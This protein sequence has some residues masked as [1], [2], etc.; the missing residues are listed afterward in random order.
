MLT[1]GQM[2]SLTIEKPAAGGRMIARVNGQVVLVSGAIPGE[3]VT[4]RVERVS[5]SVAYA[6]TVTADEPS[7]DRRRATGDPMCGGSLYSHIAYPR[8]LEIKSRVI[9]D[10][11]ARIGHV[12]LPSPIRVA[13]SPEDGYRMRARL[14]VRGRRIGFFREATHDVCDVRQTRQLLPQS[15]DVIDRLTATI[16][17]LALDAIR[18]IE[19]AENV[20]ASDRV[21]ALDTIEAIDSRI[22]DRLASADGLTGFVSASGVHG[23]P[24][25]TDRVE[26]DGTPV[27]LRRHVLAFFQGNRHLLRPLVE[28]VVAQVPAGGELVD[29]YAGVGLFA[30][31]AA[32]V[33]RIR[34]TAVEGDRYAAADLDANA[35]ATQGAV[36]P[37]HDAV[38]NF[39]SSFSTHSREPERTLIVDPPRTGMSRE[40][41]EGALRLQATRIIYVSCDVATLAR[42]SRRIIDAG[43]AIS[44]ADAFDLFPNTPHV[45]TVL[46]FDR[47]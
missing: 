45:E 33:R 20:D 14:H 25:V 29:L 23:R 46:V 19:L 26:V 39:L 12:E 17:S 1:P 44:G 38:E 6:E 28:H 24:S 42:D 2:I 18:E 7:S 43:H 3:R 9:A 15:C 36:R 8:Q 21:L 13:G 47:T 16:R 22:I 32:V 30:I 5:K 10:A 11:L 27:A 40:A 31:G 4:A 37:V 34:V 35:A 41:L